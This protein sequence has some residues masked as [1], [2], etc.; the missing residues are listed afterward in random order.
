VRLSDAIEG[1]LLNKSTRCSPRTVKTDAVLLGQF[2]RYLDDADVADVASETVRD[3]PAHHRERGLS[4]HTVKRHLAIVSA[5]YAWLG[6]PDIALVESNPTDSVPNPKLSK[7]KPRALTRAEVENLIEATHGSRNQRRDKA[8]VLFLLDTGA[9]ASELCTV[10]TDDVSFDTGKTLV[11]G[12]GS[13]QRFVYLGKR[14]LSAT[15]LYVK[16]ERPEPAQV[17]CH[18]LFLTV[19]GYPLDRHSLRHIINR[20][21]ERAGFHASPHRFRH[22]AA[23]T[24]LR[25]G[26]DLVSLQHLLGH[27]D[28]GTTRQYLNSLRDSEVQR[29][30]QKTSP[31]DNWRL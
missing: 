30:A 29:T 17:R 16:D 18:K 1:Y 10:A 8:I 31:S 19:D 2:S 15:W 6:S 21:S 12:K 9:R 22:T 23:I 11:T 3:Y 27:A 20:L 5:F 26:M 14:A 7:V 24:H 28:I 4:P 13:K 25:N